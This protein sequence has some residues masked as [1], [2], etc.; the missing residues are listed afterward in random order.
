LPPCRQLLSDDGR[1]HY[2][3]G[4]C[5]LSDNLAARAQ[6]LAARAV[7]MVP[8][9]RGYVGVDLVLGD[10]ADDS[11]D[12]IIEINPRLTTSYIGLRTLAGGNLAKAILAAAMGHALPNMNWKPGRVRFTAARIS[13]D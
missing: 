13:V 10:A 12:Q 1:F 8:G 5:P 9:L 7:G 2:L 3:G 11:R 4:E 6:R